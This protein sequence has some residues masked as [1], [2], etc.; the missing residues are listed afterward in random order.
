MQGLLG[1]GQVDGYRILRLLSRSTQS[2]VFLIAHHNEWFVLK[3][4][5]HKQY[6]KN[7]HH[8]YQ[9]LRSLSHPSIPKVYSFGTNAYGCAYYIMN[10]VHGIP[11]QHYIYRQGVPGNPNRTTCAVRILLQVSLALLE[12][13]CHGVAHLDIKSDNVLISSNEDTTLLDF[14]AS[15]RLNGNHWQKPFHGT[16]V[17]AAPERLQ[18]T[19]F[20]ERA[21][22][23]SLG[24]L[25]YRLLSGRK[26]HQTS[27]QLR[28]ERIP[29]CLRSLLQQ[30]LARTPESRPTASN[31][32]HYLNT[33]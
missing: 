16:E 28:W 1:I 27:P 2:M 3:V 10:C 18:R 31:I 4:A 7:I 29:N 9:I 17:Y 15:M 6:S 30:M 20:D 8:E 25:A 19:F 23:Y 22:I 13:H 32:V 5:S 33:L 21:D 24:Y 26:F 11:A 14:G 12:I